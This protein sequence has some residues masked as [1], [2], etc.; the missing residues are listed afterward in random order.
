MIET[1]SLDDVGTTYNIEGDR[2]LQHGKLGRHT[3]DH[4]FSFY[5]KTPS[6]F[7][8]EYGWGG[9]EVDAD[10]GSESSTKSQHLGPRFRP[11]SSAG[12]SHDGVAKTSFFDLTAP[13]AEL[14]LRC[15]ALCSAK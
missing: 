5:V 6:G 4:V 7:D 8:V 9:R 10:T 13:E 12:R 2:N 3:N 15:K 11:P 1:N 14:S